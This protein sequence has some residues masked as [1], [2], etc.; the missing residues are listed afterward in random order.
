MTRT[1]GAILG[2]AALIAAAGWVEKRSSGA[3]R[4]HRL[5]GRFV[6]ADGT[7]VHYL[8]RGEG[9]SLVMLHGLGTMVDDLVLSGLV[10]RAAEHYRVLAVDRPGYGRSPRPRDRAWTLAA[11]ADL[12]HQA[13]RQLNVY[14]PVLFGHSLGATV[15]LAYAL[16]YP[17]ERLVLLSGYYYPSLR[18]DVPLLVPPAIP[19][20]GAVMR[21]TISPLAGRA[22]WPAWL[23]LLF[24]PR[25]VPR[26]FRAFP[27]WLALRPWQLRAV[28]ED[29]A[30]VLPAL[31]AM[32]PEYA[33]LRVPTT[34]FAGAADRYVSPE[35]SRRLQ[36]EIPGSELV[37]VPGAGHMAHYA[38]PEPIMSALA[39][40]RAAALRLAS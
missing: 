23:R 2:A 1:R 25:P 38:A 4:E 30:L 7:A 6:Y 27:T 26:R 28:G 34:I 14:S 12:L 35:Q 24:S 37:V 19:V 39:R 22:L 21:H 13:L 15:A 9:P 18:L 16:R 17:V 33:K 11:Q 36:R 40:D 10:G 8:E 32:A 20:L 31:R 5:R 3:V 29:A